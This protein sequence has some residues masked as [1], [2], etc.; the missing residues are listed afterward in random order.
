MTET[1]RGLRII[2]EE[3]RTMLKRMLASGMLAATLSVSTFAH[4][5]SGQTMQSETKMGGDTMMKSGDTMKMKS[6][7]KWK[8]KSRKH[9]VHKKSTMMKNSM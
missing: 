8:H 2:E 5:Q 9:S 3:I 1:Q 4:D 6:H 7:K